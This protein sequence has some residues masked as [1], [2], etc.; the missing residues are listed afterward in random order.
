M[1]PKRGMRGLSAQLLLAVFL[2]L[3]FTATFSIGELA[4]IPGDDGVI[5]IV[6]K[7]EVVSKT[8][9]TKFDASQKSRYWDFDGRRPTFSQLS[10]MI[11]ATAIRHGLDP[12]F[13][14]ALIKV[15]SNFNPYALSCKGARGLMQL[16]PSTANMYGLK[17]YYDPVANVDAGVRHL[18]MLF[19]R[20]DHDIDL[21][22]AAYNA[23]SGAVERH[24]GVPPYD[25]TLRFIKKV[26]AAYRF[27]GGEVKLAER[28]GTFSGSGG[29]YRSVKDDGTIIIREFPGKR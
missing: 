13:V 22:L 3:V 10:A 11:K 17:N 15:E 8:S 28:I 2:S 4:S 14:M 27:F 24:G 1:R 9:L 23:G 16:I 20:Y 29:L 5:R 18:K 7:S 6:P 19:R 21:I 25:E 12:A 26:K